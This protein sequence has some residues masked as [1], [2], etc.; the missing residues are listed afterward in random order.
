V[1]CCAAKER[2]A[3]VPTA[4][5]WGNEAEQSL[6][7]RGEKEMGRCANGREKEASSEKNIMA[8][9]RG[10]QSGQDGRMGATK[11]EPGR[12]RG[13]SGNEKRRLDARD[14]PGGVFEN[15]DHAQV[16][17]SRDLENRF[18]LGSARQ[19]TVKKMSRKRARAKGRRRRR[20]GRSHLQPN[21]RD[22]HGTY[23]RE[24]DRGNPSSKS[25]SPRK[26]LSRVSL[27]LE[28]EEPSDNSDTRRSQKRGGTG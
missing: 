27:L 6:L 7:G 2:R 25:R 26:A 8:P 11:G 23:K 19:Y 21:L 24:E 3:G 14:H 12:E 4:V 15:N 20:S 5:F 10:G 28:K 13:F 16:N 17:A 18:H 22:P 1:L 9:H